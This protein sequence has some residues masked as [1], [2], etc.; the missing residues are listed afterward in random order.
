MTMP[1]YG[2]DGSGSWMAIDDVFHIK[3][4]GT[5]VIG[6]LQGSAP[7]HVGDILVCEDASWEIA[8]IEQFRAQLT[9]A[10]PGANIGILLGKGP[11]G[12][13]LRDRTVTFEAAG[14]SPGSPGWQPKKRH[15]FR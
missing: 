3:G 6:Q 8:G 2:Q 13:A 1:I 9:T 11:H 12:D 10:E 14:S 5:V 4:R 15:W 7:V